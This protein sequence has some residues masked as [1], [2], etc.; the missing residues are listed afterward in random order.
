ME[1]SHSLICADGKGR[2][3]ESLIGRDKTSSLERLIGN[4]G[5]KS[6]GTANTW[7]RATKGE[8]GGGGVTNGTL[9]VV[10]SQ[11]CDVPQKIIDTS[12]VIK[13]I[14]QTNSD[15]STNRTIGVRYFRFSPRKSI[16]NCGSG[17]GKDRSSA[18]FGNVTAIE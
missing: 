15:E 14:L 13:T 5:W 11:E 8:R 2:W 4:A 1:L 9:G 16:K 3:H 10:Y 6:G 7:R 18:L 12:P 17:D